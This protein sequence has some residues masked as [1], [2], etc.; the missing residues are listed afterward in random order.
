MPPAPGSQP[1]VLFYPAAMSDPTRQPSEPLCITPPH[2]QPILEELARLEP[3]IH[4]P[5]LGTSR[6]AIEQSMD[7]DFWEIGASGRRYSRDYV[8]AALEKRATMPYTDDWHHSDFQ[9]R[10]LAPNL[11]QLTY[12]L[13]QDTGRFT[14][15]STLWRKADPGWLIVYHQGTVVESM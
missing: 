2:L 6:A 1:S 15:R 4:W 8:L 14:Q 13:V 5:A 11:Y 10:E 7:P 3:W 12:T 9:L